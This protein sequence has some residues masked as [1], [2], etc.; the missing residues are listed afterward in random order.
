MARAFAFDITTV[1]LD[2]TRPRLWSAEGESVETDHPTTPNPKVYPMKRT[3]PMAVLAVAAA[4]AFGEPSA[5]APKPQAGSAEQIISQIEQ[6]WG[7][8]LM[9]HDIAAID[10]FVS[11]EWMMTD[12]DGALAD[13]AQSDAE[14]KSGVLTIESF[15]IDDLKVHVDGDT[16]V[17]YGLETEKSSY[18]GTDSSG[19]Y[20]FTDVF[21]K[22]HGVWKAIATHIS[23]V[24]KH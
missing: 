1:K 15:K 6:D 11:P 23:K 3:I 20:R 8:A 14:L 18:K 19:Q 4:L 5:T 10:Q 22:R 21:V 2:S 12:P 9:K 16:A 7:V 24:A 17:A 13:K